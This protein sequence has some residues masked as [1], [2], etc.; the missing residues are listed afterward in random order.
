MRTVKRVLLRTLAIVAFTGL[1][2][3]GSVGLS[4]ADGGLD[5]GAGGL[6]YQ[7][8]SESIENSTGSGA[9]GSTDTGTV[10]DS[11]SNY[12]GGYSN[13]NSTG[14]GVDNT[15]SGTGGSTDMSTGVTSG[16]GTGGATSSDTENRDVNR[17][18]SGS[19]VGGVFYPDHSDTLGTEGSDY[20]I[21]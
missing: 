10:P 15:G 11:G 16:A 7:G 8:N 13:D 2:I 17:H 9:G 18:E 12:Q 6:G 4:R 3:G 14:S 21:K 5:T 1:T 19:T 20:W